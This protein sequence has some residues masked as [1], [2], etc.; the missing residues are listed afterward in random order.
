MEQTLA[1]ALHNIGRDDLRTWMKLYPRNDPGVQGFCDAAPIL[2]KT[3]N[4][5]ETSTNTTTPGARVANAAEYCQNR[6]LHKM[7]KPLSD[8]GNPGASS[9][10][11][12]G[13]SLYC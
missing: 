11:Q 9:D 4:T 6:S 1:S 8:G 7:G 10:R 2:L 12:D 5:D 13:S 3:R